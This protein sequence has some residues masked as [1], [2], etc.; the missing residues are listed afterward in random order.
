[1]ART[2]RTH[3]KYKSVIVNKTDIYK[4]ENELNQTKEGATERL[5]HKLEWIGL[6]AVNIARERGSYH[7]LSGN[8]RSSIDYVILNDGKVVAQGESKRFS[9]KAG[10]GTRG[11]AEGQA[12]LRRLVAE[13]PKGIVLILCA[14][15]EYAAFVENVRHKDVLTSAK[16]L[17]ESLFKKLIGNKL[18]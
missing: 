8:L 5:I 10:D 17:A 2:F 1:M 14:G 16:H 6:E 3:G 4:L 18:Q 15:M 12:L 7:D 11:E 13:Y 9:G